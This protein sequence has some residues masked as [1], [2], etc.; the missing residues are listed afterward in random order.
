MSRTV[1]IDEGGIL[2]DA[3]TGNSLYCP[4]T[5]FESV[6]NTD[7]AWL[8]IVEHNISRQESTVYVNCGAY[9]CIGSFVKE[10]K[11]VQNEQLPEP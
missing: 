4:H 1:I 8:N 7:C 9:T 6:C 3:N 5:Q 11:N 10:K 2:H